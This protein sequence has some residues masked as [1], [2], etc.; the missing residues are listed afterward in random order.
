MTL[1]YSILIIL[2]FMNI[3]MGFPGGSLVKNTPVNAGDLGWEDSLEW[4]PAPVFLPRESHGQSLAG[5]SPKG[6]KKLDPT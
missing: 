6:H 1:Q 4:Q 3:Y 5:Y 2:L